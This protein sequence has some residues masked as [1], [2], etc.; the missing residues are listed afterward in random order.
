MYGTVARIKIKPEMVAEAL[1]FM[2][3]SE[4][5][6]TPPGAVAF[7]LYQMD[8]DPNEFYMVVVF[9]DKEKYFANAN[10][11]QTNAQFQEMTKF[12]AE[13]P[14]WHDGEVVYTEYTK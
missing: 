13:E 7:Y 4:G 11:P 9:E 12:F 14:Q 10:D 8:A 5:S 2:Q 3:T 1:N 6:S